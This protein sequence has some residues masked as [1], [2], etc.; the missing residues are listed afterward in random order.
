M[1]RL[2]VTGGCG[3]I[4]SNFIHHLFHAV[5]G[6]PAI[7]CPDH[8]RYGPDPPSDP[9]LHIHNLDAL[10]YAGNPAHLTG[11]D[12]LKGYRFHHADIADGAAVDAVVK[13]AKPE[14]IVHFA[15]ESHVDR[16]IADGVP[17]ARTNFLGTQVLLNA[18]RRHDVDA[19]LHVST[20]EV[21]GSIKAGSFKETDPF[22]PGS[23]YAASKA[24]ADLLAFAHH[25][26]YGLAVA[27]ARCTNN[28]GP[29]QHVEKL[30]PKLIRQAARNQPLTLY[31]TGKNVRDWLYVKDHC[32][33]LLHIL[34]LQRWGEAWNVAGGNEKTNLEI[35]RHVLTETGRPENLITHVPDRPGHD[36]R[37]SLDDGKLRATGWAPRTGF[38][39]GF[40]E[41]LD[42]MRGHG[43][44]T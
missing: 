44:K 22:R 20:D 6:A 5:G 37:Y 31:G 1:T 16:S 29:R 2:L 38:R 26:T 7:C 15:A 34:G 17:F 9:D 28:Y 23:P 33:A 40:K 10:T 3:F 13:A 21:Y 32:A 35:A 42:W 18:A 27:V 36:G 39:Q 11:V 25:N 41:T 24:G 43:G 12:R 14:A 30:L 8:G 19:F 4:G